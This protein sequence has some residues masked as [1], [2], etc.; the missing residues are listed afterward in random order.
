MARSTRRRR[1]RQA[2]RAAAVAAI[3]CLGA[4]TAGQAAAGWRDDMKSFRIGLVAADGDQGVAGLSVI[5]RAF[6]EALGVPVDILAARDYAALIDA[7]ASGRLDYAIDSTAAYATTALLCSCVEPLVAPLGDDGATGIVAVLVTRDAR[8]TGLTDLAAHRVAI[9]PPDSLAG[10]M[11]PV[12]A[13]AS[14]GTALSGDEPYLVRAESASAAEAM[15]VGGSVDAIFGWAPAPAE[16][17]TEPG[18]GTLDRLVAAGLD[19]AELSVVWKSPPLRY[20]PHA[21][22]T[23]IDSELRTI[24]VDFLTGLKS[25]RPDVYDLLERDHGGGFVAVSAADYAMAVDAIR[26]I[27]AGK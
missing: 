4:L 24:L 15:L 6:A 3:A 17:G 1:F 16:A 22:R 26:L 21:L 19:R 23:G 14:Q 8:L 27:A 7:E 20:G 11:L 13:L 5:K 2:A 25:Q 9:A 10:S 18:G 12:V